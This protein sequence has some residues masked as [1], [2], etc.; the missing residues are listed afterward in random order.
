MWDTLNGWIG[1]IEGTLF[2]DVVLPVVYD[3]GFGRYAEEAFTGTEWLLVGL[4][5]IAVM[6]LILRPREKWRPVAA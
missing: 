1:Q 4:V 3:L 2:Q 5:Q 6:A